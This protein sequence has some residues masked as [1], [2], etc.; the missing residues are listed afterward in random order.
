MAGPGDSGDRLR[1]YARSGRFQLGR[2]RNL[3]LVTVP[4]RLIFLRA[5]KPDDPGTALWSLDL[6]SG[7]ERLLAD[8]AVLLDGQPETVPAAEL[9][10]RERMREWARGIVAYSTD[11][12]GRT[13]VFALSGR[14]FA[15][16]LHTGDSREIPLAGPCVDPQIDPGGSAAGYLAGPAL[17]VVTLD[18]RVILELS[19]ADPEISYGAAEFGAA[20]EMGRPHGFWWSPDG[21]QLLAARVNERGVASWWLGDPS[22][23]AAEPVRQRYPF[24]GT[25][26]PA[27]TLLLAGLDGVTTAVDTSGAPPYLMDVRWDGAG[28]P[29]L[30]LQ[31]RDHGYREFRSVDP[32]SGA[33]ELLHA[34]TDPAWLELIPGTP[35]WLP[36]GRLLRAAASGDTHRLFAGDEPL[37][38][39]GLQV[40]GVAGTATGAG[41]GTSGRV[42]FC[43]TTDPTGLFLYGCDLATGEVV[44]LTAEPGVHAG[45]V[46]GPLL[47][48]SAETLDRDGTEVRVLD[49]AEVIATTDSL[50]QP[51]WPP[52]V[53]LLAAGQRELRT[54]V[55]F[56]HDETRPAGPL[57]ILMAPYGGPLTRLVMRA[58][59]LFYEP[60]WL[61]DQGFAVIVAD[62]RG[63]PARGPA[64]E[65]AVHLDLATPALD[66]QV[67]ALEHV[68]RQYPG[69]LDPGRVGIRGW[70]FGGYLSALAVL[71]RPDVFHAAIAGAPVTD[72]R[73][74]DSVATERYLGHP[75][76]HPEAYQR[77]SLLPLAAGLTR[78]LLL[79]HGLADDNVHPRHSLLLSQ[80]LLAAG[81]AHEILLLPGTTHMVRQPDTIEQL[82]RAHI[83]FFRR[84]LYG[85]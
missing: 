45:A 77:T 79:V 54:A 80:E 59:R 3:S 72:W 78:P 14:L 58:R 1:R 36:D 81:R 17:R 4:D 32:G 48:I 83:Q 23:A 5:L 75:A 56:P 21:R 61:A 29:L 67:A 18:G 25:A 55:L 22:Q 60:Q 76:E 35:R 57:P 69:E 84:W 15:C 10:R 9:R 31:A 66:D 11:A 49:G 33:T 19:D 82:L 43:A 51:A 47:A 50:P 30:T 6:R 42:V 73:W 74:Y 70:S 62:G 38:P 20:E 85:D 65:R 37:T 44:Q 34:D 12:A 24:A 13:A 63:S 40:L 39:P 41:S 26:N 8:P 64:W 52:R 53:T 7:Q 68:L 16:D 28:P 46:H 27:V 71:R 2:P